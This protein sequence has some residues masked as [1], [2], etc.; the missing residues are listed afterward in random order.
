MSATQL[1]IEADRQHPGRLVFAGQE[2]SQLWRADEILH[3]YDV[4]HVVA[5]RVDH[6][7]VRGFVAGLQPG[8]VDKCNDE[9]VVR[10]RLVKRLGHLLSGDTRRRIAWQ[11]DERM[12]LGHLAERWERQRQGDRHRD[13]NPDHRPG[14]SHHKIG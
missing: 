6:L 8:F 4:G 9:E 1:A 7:A 3:R 13:P 5:Y 12:L 14:P 10:P 11:N 2:L